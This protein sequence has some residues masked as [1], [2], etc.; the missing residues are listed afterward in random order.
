MTRNVWLNLDEWELINQ[1]LSEQKWHS[2]QLSKIEV[3]RWKE[4][5]KKYPRK[6][7][8]VGIYPAIEQVKSPRALNILCRENWRPQDMFSLME[9]LHDFIGFI[10]T[11]CK[12]INMDT[13]LEE[14]ENIRNT[15]YKKIQD[16]DKRIWF[17]NDLIELYH[18]L[19]DTSSFLIHN[20]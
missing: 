20:D 14:W 4:D 12:T 5:V 1:E 15:M 19:S 13:T 7:E 2:F 16:S 3:K 9:S 11:H 8:R 17:T 10:V 6:F 18:S